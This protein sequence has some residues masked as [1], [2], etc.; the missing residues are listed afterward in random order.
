VQTCRL[1]GAQHVDERV[2]GKVDNRCGTEYAQ[3]SAL[4]V[5]SQLV[6]RKILALQ[7]SP[8][9]P[10]VMHFRNFTCDVICEASEVRSA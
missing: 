10:E 6:R 9:W 2:C 8:Q 7:A 3:V 5:Y 1:D 4:A